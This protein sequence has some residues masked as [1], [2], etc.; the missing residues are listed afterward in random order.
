M[1]IYAMRHFERP[2]EITFFT[3]LTEEGKLNANRKIEELE[4][5]HLDIIYCSP[6]I[7][8]IQSIEPYCRKHNIKLNIENSIYECLTS[9][10]FTIDNYKHKHTINE[11]DDLINY[12]YESYLNIDDLEL[13]NYNEDGIRKRT[14]EFLKFLRKKYENTNK[15]I[16]LVSHKSTINALLNKENLYEKYELGEINLL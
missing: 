12:E 5:L 13:P 11:N 15:N 10:V 14:S 7:R 1:K 16:L 3:E 9:S 2:S 4:S 6:F 8:T